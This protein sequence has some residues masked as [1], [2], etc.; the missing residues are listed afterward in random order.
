MRKEL[1]VIDINK[2]HGISRNINKANTQSKE[3]YKKDVQQLSKRRENKRN[4]KGPRLIKKI[5]RYTLVG[6]VGALAINGAISAKEK[7]DIYKEKAAARIL[8]T[9]KEELGA[10]E[11]YDYSTP[12]SSS[13]GKIDIVV[14]KDGKTYRYLEEIEDL[15]RPKVVQ[16][17]L[18]EEV[19]DAVQIAAIAQDGKVFDA[20]RANKYADKI[21]KG[22]I[23]LSIDE[24]AVEDKQKDDDAVR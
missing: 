9:V 23:N 24:K 19:V 15:S 16:D 6:V 1:E 20:I 18:G 4:I 22:E 5:I 12:T 8:E 10:D 11:I 2:E 3:Q 14:K 17:D 21:E 7:I 13:T